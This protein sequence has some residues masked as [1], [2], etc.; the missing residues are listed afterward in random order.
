MI[1]RRRLS[2][3]PYKKFIINFMANLLKHSKYGQPSDNLVSNNCGEKKTVSS[4]KH[5]NK[6]TRKLVSSMENR[7]YSREV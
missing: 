3:Y 7:Y 4:F 2:E 1:I 6:N 5:R